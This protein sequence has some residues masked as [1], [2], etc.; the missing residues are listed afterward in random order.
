MMGIPGADFSE[1]WSRR[2]IVDFDDLAVNFIAKQD[3]ITNKRASGRPQD[4]I[5]A[6]LLS[7]SE[8]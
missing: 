1:A 3:L 2:E 4:L 6:D 8:A 7:Q 5:D